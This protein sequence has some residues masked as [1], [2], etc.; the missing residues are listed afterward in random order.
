MR[1]SKTHSD[2]KLIHLFLDML[3]AEQGA[4]YGWRGTHEIRKHRQKWGGVNP[5]PSD[6]PLQPAAKSWGPIGPHVGSRY[7][8]IDADLRFV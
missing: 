8:N 3:A 1:S 5:R 4:A 2:A 7:D 6:L